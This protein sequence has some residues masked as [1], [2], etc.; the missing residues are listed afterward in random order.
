MK[1]VVGAIGLAFVASVAF[2]QGGTGGGGVGGGGTGGGG[3]RAPGGAVPGGGQPGLTGPAAPGT[4]T[5][6]SPSRAPLTVVRPQPEV[7]QP[8]TMQPPGAIQPPTSDAPI[9]PGAG[10]QGGSGIGAP[11][12]PPGSVPVPPGAPTSAAA[13]G[14]AT[15]AVQPPSPGALVIAAPPTSETAA[16]GGAPTRPMPADA[17]GVIV[18]S[19]MP[20]EVIALDTDR[21]CV[22]VRALDG[23]TRSYRIAR[24]ADGVLA[25]GEQVVLEVQRPLFASAADAPSA[26]PRMTEPNGQ[27]RPDASIGVSSRAGVRGQRP[28]TRTTL[29]SAGHTTLVSPAG[30]CSTR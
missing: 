11:V 1:S 18:E 13:P 27:A 14:A 25:V 22:T 16:G 15:V 7:D 21:S 28:E 6:S 8:N 19:M 30:S 24:G 20:A 17:I 4:P 5:V 2:A 12:L 3:V 9:G 29:S 26:S 23:D 10:N